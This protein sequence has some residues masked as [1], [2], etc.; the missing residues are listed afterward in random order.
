MLFMGVFASSVLLYQGAKQ[1]RAIGDIS[2]RDNKAK[3]NSGVWKAF[4]VCADFAPGKKSRDLDKRRNDS[5]FGGDDGA[6][7]FAHSL[8]GVTVTPLIKGSI[9]L[10]VNGQHFS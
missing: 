5:L 4:V 3:A 2:E 6:V 7:V 8:E 9:N 1:Q 10:L